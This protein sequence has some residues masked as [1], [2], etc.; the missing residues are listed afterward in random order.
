[1]NQ[2]Y[3][4]LRCV[5]VLAIMDKNGCFNCSEHGYFFLLRLKKSVVK[6]VSVPSRGFLVLKHVLKITHTLAASTEARSIGLNMVNLICVGEKL[7]GLQDVTMRVSVFF[8]ST[9]AQLAKLAEL[10]K[11]ANRDFAVCF[12]HVS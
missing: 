1:M 11:L 2:R 6:V 8:N 3:G 9:V 4:C 5:E 10:A 12:S 7:R